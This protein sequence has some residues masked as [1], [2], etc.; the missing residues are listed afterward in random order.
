M[1]TVTKTPAKKSPVVKAAAKKVPAKKASVKKKSEDVLYPEVE[2]RIC[3]GED[4]IDED[5]A[6]G[7][8]GWSELPEDSEV[9]HLLKDNEGKRI[10]CTNNM[11]N[12]PLYPAIVTQLCQEI[13]QGNWVLNGETIIIGRTGKVLNGQHEL[14]AL[15]MACRKYKEDPEAFPF[16]H[17][18]NT[19]PFL[20]KLVAFGIEETDR[21]INTMD[22]GKGR[23]MADA[24]YRSEY[25]RD[26]NMSQKKLLSKLLDYAIRLLWFRTGAS[27]DAYAPKRTHAEAEKF[28][29][30]HLT[31][32]KCIRFIAEEDTEKGISKILP[33]GTAAGLMYLMAT[34]ESDATEYHSS[35]PPH[36]GLLSLTMYE[37]AEA[38]WIAISGA[39]RAM[40]PLRKAIGLIYEEGSG[41]NPERMAVVIKAWLAFA[42]KGMM[43]DKDLELKYIKDEDDYKVLAE[44][45]TCGGIDLGRPT[46]KEDVADLSPDEIQRRA[47]AVKDETLDMQSD[48]NKSAKKAAKKAAGGKKFVESKPVV[49]KNTSKT[50]EPKTFVEGETLWVNPPE[51]GAEKYRVQYLDHYKHATRGIYVKAKVAKGYAMAGKQM[52]ISIEYISRS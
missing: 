40:E 14:I 35:N 3:Q 21:I 41:T 47:Q 11:I 42:E 9:E 52:D 27:V 49:K 20:E 30:R 6:K 7:L 5:A 17:D 28:L 44:C 45:P 31:L 15:I 32:L 25:F 48:E 10:L 2:V 34:S 13:L 33:A 19:S 51:E 46:D 12:R 50:I 24:F 37:K 39:D 1:P 29:D 4:A 43:S 18:Q 16:W 23:S 36:E 38:F 8:M 26:E 22:T